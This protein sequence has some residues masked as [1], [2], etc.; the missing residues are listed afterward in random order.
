MAK[1][2]SKTRWARSLAK[3]AKSEK[4]NKAE[5]NC[6]SFSVTFDF[7]C[8]KDAFW[9][10]SLANA[11]AAPY[12]KFLNLTLT[13]TNCDV[14]LKKKCFFFG[15]SSNQISFYCNRMIILVLHSIRLCRGLS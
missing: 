12:P 10:A 6:T 3:N 8:K 11:T 4:T 7:V 1:F 15:L 14:R 13:N 2:T 5:K 9:L